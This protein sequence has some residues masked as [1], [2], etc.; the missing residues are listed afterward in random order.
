MNAINEATIRAVL[1][2][3]DDAYARLDDLADQLTAVEL[4]NRELRK[5]IDTLREE[6]MLV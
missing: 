1:A 2:D 3:R 5:Q 6:G 4:E